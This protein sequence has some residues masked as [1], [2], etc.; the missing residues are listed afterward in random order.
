MKYVVR[1]VRDMDDDT[2]AGK[3]IFEG[4]HE[5]CQSF[6]MGVAYVNDTTLTVEVVK[7]RGNRKRSPA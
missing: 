1:V 5:E 7:K 4:T 3:Q 6:A 2:L